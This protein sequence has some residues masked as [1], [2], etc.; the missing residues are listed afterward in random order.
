[1][2]R[3][4]PSVTKRRRM[5]MP[6]GRVT[7]AAPARAAVASEQAAA[8]NREEMICLLCEAAESD[9]TATDEP[10]PDRQSLV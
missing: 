5:P 4:L 1:M 8:R 9:L 3:A 7:L 2:R 10:R 6:R